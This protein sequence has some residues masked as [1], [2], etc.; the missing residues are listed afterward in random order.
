MVGYNH[1]AKLKVMKLSDSALQSFAKIYKEVYGQ[2]LTDAE[3]SKKATALLS[4]VRAVYCSVENASP[5]QEGTADDSNK[6]M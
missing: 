3:V 1:T 6:Y 4:L 5:Q 2:D